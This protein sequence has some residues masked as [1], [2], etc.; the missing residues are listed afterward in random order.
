MSGNV[1]E[2]CNDWYNENYYRNSPQTNP[3]GP[4]EG[5]PRVLRGGGWDSVGRYVRV[6]FRYSPGGR[7]NYGLRLAL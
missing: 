6:S 3:T 5:G 4:S 1:W 7:F 2:W